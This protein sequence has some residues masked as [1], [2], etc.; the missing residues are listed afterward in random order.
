LPH[1]LKFKNG[2]RK[3]L[4]KRAMQGILPADIIDRPKKG[5]GIP[6]ATWLRSMPAEPPLSAVRGVHMDRVGAAWDEHR[7]GAKDHRLFLWTW[8]SVQSLAYK[9]A[10]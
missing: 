9:D 5:F 6:T 7:R 10:A 8:L 4:L 2:E 1:R 3:Y